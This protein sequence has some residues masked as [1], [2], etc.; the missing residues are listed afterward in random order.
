MEPT[1]MPDGP[2]CIRA[3]TV[4]VPAMV[5]LI[6]ANC[7]CQH[8]SRT[9]GWN[10]KL[11]VRPPVTNCIAGSSDGAT[12]SGA[13]E[14]VKEPEIATG[15]PA[16]SDN[17]NGTCCAGLT[18]FGSPFDDKVPIAGPIAMEKFRVS[19]TPEGSVTRIVTV[20]EP[21]A[22]GVPCKTPAGVRVRPVGKV[23]VTDHA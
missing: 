3:V 9:V 8:R 19:L 10:E 13:N 16:D 5:P 21:V 15:Y 18:A 7:G 6:R 20:A 11:I 14:I 1:A 4:I 2:F 17:V 22:F 12:A 23:P